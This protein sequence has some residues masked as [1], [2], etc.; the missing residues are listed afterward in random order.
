MILIL[1]C[2][3]RYHKK[4]KFQS[5]NN[6]FKGGEAYDYLKKNFRRKNVHPK[7]DDI[8]RVGCSS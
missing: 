5:K 2:E 3:N 4:K 8:Y 7:K 1:Y 6:N